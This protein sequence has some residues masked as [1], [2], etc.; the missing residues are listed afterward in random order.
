MTSPSPLLIAQKNYENAKKK[1]KGEDIDER[2][3]S[4]EDPYNCTPAM[5]SQYVEKLNK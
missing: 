3:E 2:E 4:T 5:V 1:L